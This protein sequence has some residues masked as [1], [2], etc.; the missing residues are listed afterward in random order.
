MSKGRTIAMTMNESP[1][2]YTR[3]I[4]L[5]FLFRFFHLFLLSINMLN[6]IRTSLEILASKVD[7]VAARKEIQFLK[8]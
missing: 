4:P 2:N 6:K 5:K 8:F 7:H 3:P 1:T